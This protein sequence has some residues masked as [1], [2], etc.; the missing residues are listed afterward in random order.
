MRSFAILPAAGRSLRMGRPKLLLPWNGGLVIDQVLKT[1]LASG[2]SHVVMVVRAED[3]ALIERVSRHPIELI[4]AEPPPAD[5]KASILLG[6]GRIAERFAPRDDD[7]WLVAPADL[8]RL[9]ARSIAA[10]L[11]ARQ[12]GSPGVLVASHGARRGHPVL[13]PWPLAREFAG[14][15]ADVSLKTLVE[16]QSVRLVEVDDNGAT[17]DI[18]TRDD[19]DRLRPAT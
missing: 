10:V 8:P 15:P 16:R 14:S 5:M 6:L 4:L 3:E 2:V 18:D 7:V 11:A 17:Q 9:E 1:W 19:Y 12:P 13:L